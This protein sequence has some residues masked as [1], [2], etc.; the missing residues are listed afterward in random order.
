MYFLRLTKLKPAVEAIASAAWADTVIGGEPAKQVERVLDVRQ[1]E[2]CWVIGTVYMEMPLKP[3][4]L[5][6]VAK[7]RWISAPALTDKYFTLDE[8]GDG[9]MIM[10]EDES[11]RIRLV[12]GILQSCL[13]VTGC[14]VAALGTENAR[15]EF[16]AIGLKFADLPP[17]PGRWALS[18]KSSAEKKTMN[19]KAAGPAGKKGAKSV[20][21]EPE[22]VDMTD[23]SSN[24]TRPGS[25]GKVAIVSGLEF[26]GTDTSYA[27]E[28]DL[29]LEYLLGGRGRPE[30]E[31]IAIPRQK[32]RLRQQHVQPRPLSAVGRLPVGAAAVDAR[33]TDARRDGPVQRKRSA[34]AGALGHV[35]A[36]ADLRARSI[37]RR[38]S[39]QR[40]GLA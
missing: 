14:L 16:E 3:N 28:L 17:Q 24:A 32:V 40:T 31:G 10:L 25:K 1:G 27:V 33:D 39:A 2:L 4:V 22:D 15:G 29:L 20:K 12:G 6:D 11:G 34:A 13:L 30:Q 8:S 38:C 37:A 23:A 7:D 19:G 26:S 35:R 36:V 9:A 18:N 5:D 21:A